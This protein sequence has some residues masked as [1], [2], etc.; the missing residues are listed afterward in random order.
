MSISIISV[1]DRFFLIR[2]FFLYGKSIRKKKGS[3]KEKNR[4]E[5]R[6]KRGTPEKMGLCRSGLY[7]YWELGKKKGQI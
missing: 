2:L 1:G 7:Q 4:A 6:G 5:G 3:I